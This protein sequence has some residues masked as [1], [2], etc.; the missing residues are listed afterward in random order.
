MPASGV[1]E[2]PLAP[3][4]DVTGTGAAVVVVGGAGVAGAAGPPNDTG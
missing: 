4:A 1:I 2:I 3:G